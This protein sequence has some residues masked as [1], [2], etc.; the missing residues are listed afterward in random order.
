MAVNAGSQASC[1]GCDG[2]DGQPVQQK[3]VNAGEL[4]AGPTLT[5]LWNAD[6]PGRP[7]GG[8]GSSAVR[9]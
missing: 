1:D 3:A 5:G 7:S 6:D 9:S 4:R 8:R 2:C